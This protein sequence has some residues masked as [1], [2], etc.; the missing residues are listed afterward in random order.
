MILGDTSTNNFM[1]TWSVSSESFFLYKISWLGVKTLKKCREFDNIQK[2]NIKTSVC[3]EYNGQQNTIYSS[4]LLVF[5]EHIYLRPNQSIRHIFY[6]LVPDTRTLSVSI[7]KVKKSDQWLRKYSC[8]LGRTWA[9][10]GVCEQVSVV[11]KLGR[12]T[13]P[14]NRVPSFKLGNC[15]QHVKVTSLQNYF[16]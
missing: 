14:R 12:S 11:V 3:T 1:E 16:L 7:C 10:R 2:H 6:V 5:Y 9:K 15:F 13:T 4:F 8:I